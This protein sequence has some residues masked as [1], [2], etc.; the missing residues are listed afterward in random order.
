MKKNG[1][2]V[3]VCFSAVGGVPKFPRT[4][5]EVGQF[6]IVNDF[7]A[8]ETRISHKTHEQ[9]L[10]D[11]QVSLVAR[12]AYTYLTARLELTTPLQPGDFGENFTTSGLGELGDILPG[13]LLHIGDEVVLQ[14]TEQNKPC[15]NLTR[16]H[17]FMVKNSYG[18]RGLLAIVLEGVGCMILPHIPITI[19]EIRPLP[20][21]IT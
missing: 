5:V 20:S 1:R 4:H 12:E 14:V 11:R 9:K 13:T 2:I 3:A 17:E 16:Y 6:G 18:R 7:H 10:N 15:N 8:G 21:W 19:G